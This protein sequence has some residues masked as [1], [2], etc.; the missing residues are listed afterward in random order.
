M[1]VGTLL[2]LVA[3]VATPALAEVDF[4]RL[5]GQGLSWSASDTNNV[6]IDF[7]S[8]PGSMQPVYFTKDQNILSTL[9]GWS[10]FKFPTELDYIDGE[11][12]R[13]WRAANGFYWFTAGVI[14][15]AWVDGDSLSYS[16]PVSRGATSEWYTIDVGVPVPAD[17][18]GFF[19]PPRGFRADGTL[20]RDDVV[21]AF[22]LSVSAEEDPVLNT[23]NGDGDYHPLDNLIAD[24]PLNLDPEVTI[25]FPKQYVRM[26]RYKRN[27]AADSGIS[28]AYG[29]Q[30]GGTIGEFVLFGEGVAKRV[31]YTTKILD[32]GR[33][34]NFG[35]IFWD[36]TPMRMVDGQAVEAED[37]AASLTVEVR[38]GRDGDPNIY[39]EF[40]DTGAERVVSFEHY[41]NELKQPG[42]EYGRGHPGGQ[43]GVAGF[44]DLRYRQLDVLVFSYYRTGDPDPFG[45]GPFYPSADYPR[46]RGLL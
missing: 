8:A 20:L 13:I 29:G 21:G 27:E 5:G 17:Q 2:G 18:V 38:S 10:P 33:E 46:K 14:T 41:A 30:Q 31:F 36:V 28:G 15:P 34:V 7:D 25:D 35:R 6:F 45:A 26:I 32:L 11:R 12:P 37:A 39:H 43:T 42:P 24:I 40:T 23:E 1:L 4:W 19:T 3:L 9:D 22:E 44:G 16:P